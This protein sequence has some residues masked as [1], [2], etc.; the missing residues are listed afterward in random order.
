M[1]VG[2]EELCA[3]LKASN[4]FKDLPNEVIEELASYFQTETV[5]GGSQFITEGKGSDTLFLLVSGR[6]RVSRTLPSGER[7]MYNEVLPGDCVGETGMILRQPRTADITATRESVVAVLNYQD[8]EDV[9]IK[10]PVE[11]SRAFSHAIY[12]H[13]RHERQ[14][15]KRGRAQSFY[16]LPIHSSIKI[17]K[18]TEQLFAALSTHGKCEVIDEHKVANMQDFGRGLDQK[19]SENDFLLFK[20]KPDFNSIETTNFEHADQLIIVADSEKSPALT[21]IEENLKELP[22]FELMRRH[23]LLLHPE[24][25]KFCSDRHIWN[26]HRKCERVYPAKYDQ[27][28]DYERLARF[29]LEK[30]IGLVLGGGGARGFAHLGILRAFEEA[31]IPIDII[32]GNSMGAL[33]GASYVAGIPL[34]SIHKEI[35]KHSKSGMKL[36]LPVVSILSNRNLAGAFQ[37]ALGE[38]NIENLWVP[39]F[40]AACNLTDADTYV[41]D[42]GPLWKAVLASNSPAGLFPPVVNDGMLLVDGAV[43]ENVPVRAMR[44]RLSTPLERRRGN[45]LVVAIDVD[46]KER[47]SVDQQTKDLSAWGKLKSHFSRTTDTLPGIVDI[48]MQVAH[49]GGLSQRQQ[50]KRGAD[51]YLEPPL[52]EFKIMDYKKAEKIIEVGY[53][54]A[55]QQISE[56]QAQVN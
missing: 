32:G 25:V 50:T 35:L 39:F 29:L 4:D 26:E 10:Y 27:A 9:L 1:T 21:F 5:K 48:L 3:L 23:L 22:N 42:S 24:D 20:G 53:Q 12:R 56:L 34:E 52:A 6:L 36:T 44:Q 46:V 33:I 2:K 38:T 43:L 19:E 7:L 54:Y 40:A 47:F 41:L 11:L 8:Y 18:I 13:L 16:L 51:I 14:I 28:T 45:G 17:D 31:K 49:I 15:D 55:N 30:A 37:D